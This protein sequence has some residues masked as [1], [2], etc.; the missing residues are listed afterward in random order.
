MFAALDEAIDTIFYRP[1]VVGV[2][3]AVIVFQIVVLVMAVGR[4]RRGAVLPLKLHMIAAAVIAVLPIVAGISVHAARALMFEA[5]ASPSGPSEK[6]AAISRSLAGQM[7]TIPLAVSVTVLAVLIWIVASTYTLSASRSDGR[8][9][10]YAPVAL[11]GVGLFPTALGAVQ[12]NAGLIKSFASMAGISPDDK[13]AVVSR[14]LVAGR[15]Q[16]TLYARVSM[17]AIPIL[18]TI[19]VVLIIVSDRSRAAAPV[20][21]SPR[22][23][24]LPLALSV[25]ALVVAALLVLGARPMAAENAMAWPSAPGGGLVFPG[26]PVTPD[27]VGPDAAERAPV[28]FVRRDSLALDGRLREDFESLETDLVTL[29]NN[30]GLLHPGDDFNE[31]ALIVA[32]P[33][34]S[35]DRLTSTLRAVRSAWYYR[36]L[37]AFTKTETLVRPVIGKLERTT[38]TGARIKVAFTDEKDDEDPG[39]W[40]DAVSLRVQAF[41]DYAGFAR[42]LVALRRAG[43][44]V[45]VKVD[46]AAR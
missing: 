18:A 28:I 35:I 9:S 43:K 19:A 42:R 3:L 46:R 8:A 26:G 24:R 12:W 22:S 40:K 10:G 1:A 41:A 37:F 45:I 7:N 11:V 4:R 17:A 38:V 36:P 15:A 6:A 31:M 30:F 14:A 34:T 33:G 20:T 5:V 25:A 27:L 29:R 32:E 21:T 44:P 23:P 2:G 39:E 13:L 16:L